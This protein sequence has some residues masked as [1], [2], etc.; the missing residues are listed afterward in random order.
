MVSIKCDVGG[1]PL[2]NQLA[3]FLDA[4]II[5]QEQLPS[6]KFLLHINRGRLSLSVVCQPKL[7]PF[8]LDFNRARP[9]KGK[10]PLLRAI[11]TNTRSVIDA[12]AGWCTDAVHLARHGLQVLAME[13]NHLVVALTTHA[14]EQIDAP[15]LS[16]RLTLMAGNSIELL[17]RLA[18]SPDVI[19]LD[20]MYPARHKKSATRKRL[21][22]LRDIVGTQNNEQTLNEQALFDRALFD[23]AMA[24]AKQRVVV[25]RPHYAAPLAAGKV[26]ETRSKLVRFD[27]YK[28]HT[29]EL[30]YT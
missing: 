23:C 13:Q 2:A 6:T 5:K 3:A 24:W 1:S 15:D 28:P 10:D 4:P 11:G 25:K 12:T 30:G 29:P 20:P 22:L 16:A 18:Q 7:K 17:E 26:G 21:T 27:I 9:S 14:V 19:Y 8:R